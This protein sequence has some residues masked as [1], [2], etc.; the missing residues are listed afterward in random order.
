VLEWFST[1]Q[2]FIDITLINC[3]LVLSVFAVF[4]AGVFSLASVGFMSVG[5]YTT[6]I[7]TTK[8]GLPMG[9]GI[10]V[11]AVGTALAGLIVGLIVLRLEGIYLALATLALA[12]AV[13]VLIET[14]SLTGADQGIIG[15]PTVTTTWIVIPILVVVAAAFQVVHRSHHGRA[16]HLLR[17]DP[18]IARSLGVRVRGYK[19]AALAVSGLLAGLAGALNAHEVGAISPDQYTF[20]LLVIALTYAVVGGVAYWLGPLV[21]A[22]G[23]GLLNEFLHGS[24][25][26]IETA[27][28]GFVLIALMFGAPQG[29]GDPRLRGLVT[30]AVRWRRP[31][32]ST[33][34]LEEIRQ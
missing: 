31:R 11:A 24:G 22:I 14:I 17:A 25:T 9:V 12:Q 33:A 8:E 5:A 28:Y 19:L 30:A 15:I 1:N 32:R 7:L 23:L 27:V 21:A 20:S 10:I 3:L 4:Q 2:F 13:L 18:V 6:A 26:T 29:L 34:E 16:I